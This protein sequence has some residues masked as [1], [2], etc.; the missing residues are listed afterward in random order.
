MQNKDATQCIIAFLVPKRRKLLSMTSNAI[1]EKFLEWQSP[2]PFPIQFATE[3]RK[4]YRSIDVLEITLP[5]NYSIRKSYG[6]QTS[7]IVLRECT[8][9]ITYL[10]NKYPECSVNHDA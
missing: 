9:I 4:D 7:K 6:F 3:L 2:K 10:S 5:E 1:Y 8:K